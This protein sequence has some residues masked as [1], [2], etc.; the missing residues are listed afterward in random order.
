MRNKTDND[1]MRLYQQGDNDAFCELHAR[2]QGMLYGLAYTWLKE[3]AP[4][5]ISD[6]H[7]IVQNV[8]AWVHVN[9]HRFQHGWVK[10][11]LCSTTIR[12]TRNHVKHER[13]KQRDYRRTRKLTP[14]CGESE[15]LS[16]EWMRPKNGQPAHDNALACG[17]IEDFSPEEL[18]VLMRQCLSVLE[19]KH[20]QVV[21]MIYF[22]GCTS[23]EVADELGVPKTTIDWYKREALKKMRSALNAA[24]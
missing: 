4:E 19:T 10:P 11:W 12:L 18:E 23:Q 6:A 21:Q 13:T 2:Y 22:K 24:T 16:D 9:R 20:E 8:F 7:D 15:E 17:M 3:L 5:L 14:S 1:L